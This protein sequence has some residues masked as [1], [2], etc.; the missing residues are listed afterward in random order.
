M[1]LKLKLVHPVSLPHN[2]GRS[3]GF[4]VFAPC[5]VTLPPR[6]TTMVSLGIS[7]EFSPEYVGL[8]WDRSGL[9]K[10]GITVFGGV[11]DADYR[12]EWAVCLHNSTD[13]DYEIHAGDRIAQVLFQRVEHPTITL[14]GDLSDSNRGAGG[15]G[16]T[17]R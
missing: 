9:G 15:F 7:T 17:G 3:A 5:G 14:V 4:D 10:R 2:D 13:A 8:M 6:T 11:I 16:S 12:G 1:Q